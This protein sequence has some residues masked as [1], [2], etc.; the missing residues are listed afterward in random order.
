[1]RREFDG[2]TVIYNPMGNRS[3]AVVFSQPR[4]SVATGQTAREH[5]LASPDGDIYL[6]PKPPFILGA[7]IS[8]VQ[9]QEDEGVRFT[10]HGKQKDILAILKD[11]GF[12]W[13]RLRIFHN[14]KAEGYSKKGSGTFIWE[15]TKWDG[16]ALFDAKGNTKPE[17]EVYSELAK[18]YSNQ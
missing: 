7:D 1:M 8:W 17:I 5:Q 2:G 16:P 12:N 6:M 9:E 11:H 18:E 3:V 15:P 10:D 14:P 13:I 4:T